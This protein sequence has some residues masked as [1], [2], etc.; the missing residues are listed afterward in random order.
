M[1]KRVLFRSRWLPWALLLPQLVIVGI[2]F[3]WP[4]SQAV[5]QSVQMEDA[6]GMSREFVGLENF[7]RLWHDPA[8]LGSFKITALF[9]VLVAGIGIV[10]ALVLAIFAD[11]ITRG[12]MVYR[13][14]LIMP[15]AVRV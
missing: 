7:Q 13:T 8:Y 10:L 6:F 5:L 4:A 11:R 2:F 9:S 15:Y 3:F 1:E 12:A 14:L